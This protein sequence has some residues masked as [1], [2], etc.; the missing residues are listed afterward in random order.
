MFYITLSTR[1]RLR[2]STWLLFDATST[3]FQLYNGEIKIAF[4]RDDNDDDARFDLDKHAELDFYSVSSLRNNISQLDMS[5]H[6]TLIPSQP[7]FDLS[8]L[9]CV[10]S[11]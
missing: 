10:L 2:A 3:I 4:Q 11:R 9:C 7:V 6:S 5:L 8:P 1:S